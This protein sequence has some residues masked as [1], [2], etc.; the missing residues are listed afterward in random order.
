MNFVLSF[1]MKSL[2]N[3]FSYIICCLLKFLWLKY[4]IVFVF[5]LWKQ[6]HL[7]TTFL[8]Q[9]GNISLTVYDRWN[10]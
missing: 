9:S 2:T 10:S 4:A 3:R 8:I 6:K 5:G 1:F 7:T